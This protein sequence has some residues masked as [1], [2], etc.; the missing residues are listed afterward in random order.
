MGTPSHP[1]SVADGRTF[2]PH[3]GTAHYPFGGQLPAD[4]GGLTAATSVTAAG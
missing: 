4:V 2:R 3:P 1:L